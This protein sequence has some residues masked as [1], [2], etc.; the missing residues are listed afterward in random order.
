MMS[1]TFQQQLEICEYKR[2]RAF[3]LLKKVETLTDE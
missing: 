2:K 1:I 3:L